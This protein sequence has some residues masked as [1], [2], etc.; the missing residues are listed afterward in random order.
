MRNKKILFVTDANSIHT[1]KWVDYFIDKKYDVS[2]ATFASN[3]ITKCKNIY[4]LSD[5]KINVSGGNYHYLLGIIKL[6]KIM[7]ELKPDIVNAHYSYSVG[8]IT[9]L[10]INKSNISTSF[11]VTCHGSDILIPP[12]PFITN[13]INKFV[14]K[15]CDKVFA[16]SDQIKDKIVDFGIDSNKIFIGQYGIE[17]EEK[18][19]KKD[20]DIISNRNYIP[21]SRTE[22]LLEMLE[23][24]KNDNLKIVFVL[25]HISD[26]RLNQFKTKYPHITFY[27]NMP[28][29]D[30]MEFLG[31]A[32]I[33]ISATKSDGTSLSLME[34]M[35]KKAIPIVSNIVSNRSWILDSVNGYLFDTKEQF[36]NSIENVLKDKNIKMSDINIKLIDNKCN[37]HK[38]M[39]E[40][41]KFL[42]KNKI[43][44]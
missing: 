6:A 23:Y 17:I 7:Q 8:F 43:Y 37:Y 16:V 44:T 35:S 31:R 22:L 9:L 39:E 1:L 5:R 38:Q 4:F 19:Y 27:S 26:E 21:N 36:I 20:I 34:A 2:L 18:I 25:P 29:S 32:K 42:L 13:K 33:Y 12:M 11:S 15:R 10:A 40:I 24:F 14:L 30:M 3:N 41:E 28:Y